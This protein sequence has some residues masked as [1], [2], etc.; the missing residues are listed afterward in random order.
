MKILTT[1]DPFLRHK[2]K[3]VLKV[4][5][6]TLTQIDDMFD[7]LKRSRNPQGVGLAATQVGLDK[8]IF[9]LLDKNK[10]Q[11]FINPKIVTK[12]S[13]LISQVYTNE[14]DR[15]LE[16]CLSMPKLWGFVDR[17]IKV[18]LTYQDIN[19][20]S[21]RQTFSDI[22]AAYVQHEI[23]HLNGVLFTDHILRQ[24]GQ[25]FLEDKGHLAPIDLPH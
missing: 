5:S 19:L 7:L 18:T 16:G 20:T 8:R 22:E 10:R 21:H 13:Q 3:P 25:L 1:P 4:D 2:A 11:V 14:D 23:D 9:I 17:P 6:Q 12:S 15:W 24:R